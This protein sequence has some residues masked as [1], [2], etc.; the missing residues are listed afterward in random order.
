MRG[1]EGGVGNKAK[2][3]VCLRCSVLGLKDSK[4]NMLTFILI[5]THV[6]STVNGDIFV[7]RQ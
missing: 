1:E 7:E 5:L 2:V 3:N 6:G 4:L